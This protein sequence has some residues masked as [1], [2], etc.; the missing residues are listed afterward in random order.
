M[1]DFGKILL[2]FGALA[3]VFIVIY[4]VP[5]DEVASDLGWAV[6]GCAL[7]AGAIGLWK[8]IRS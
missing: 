3:V 8:L 5:L 2:G 7:I 1:S 6:I 4:Q